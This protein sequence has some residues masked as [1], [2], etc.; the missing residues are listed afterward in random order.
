FSQFATVSVY[1]PGCI[2]CSVALESKPTTTCAEIVFDEGGTMHGVSTSAFSPGAWSENPTST[3]PGVGKLPC[4]W[5]LNGSSDVT[6]C[7]ADQ[8]S[9]HARV[10]EIS[11]SSGGTGAIDVSP[12]STITRDS[13][14]ERSIVRT[15]PSRPRRSRHGFVLSSP[16]GR[17]LTDCVSV[18]S[19][20]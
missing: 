17:S 9:T 2:P 3:Q 15:K 12:R 18:A 14:V 13:P 6:S 8:R 1:T 5:M 11:T 19:Q 10:G 20:G 4:T 7:G 16:A